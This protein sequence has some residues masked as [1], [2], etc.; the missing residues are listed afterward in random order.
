MLFSFFKMY[1]LFLIFD[2]CKLRFLKSRKWNMNEC[3]LKALP[4]KGP[5]KKSKKAKKIKARDSCSFFWL[6]LNGKKRESWL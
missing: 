6:V 5:A 3:F 4:T 2:L 1:K